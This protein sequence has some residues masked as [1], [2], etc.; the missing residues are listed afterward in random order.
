MKS[1]SAPGRTS[2]LPAGMPALRP[3][4]CQ[5]G[6]CA[7]G[8]VR[9]DWYPRGNLPIPVAAWTEVPSRLCLPVAL[10]RLPPSY[11]LQCSVAAD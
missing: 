10:F 8:N 5:D 11:C 3:G 2:G 9:Q 1:V 4:A 7:A 6:F